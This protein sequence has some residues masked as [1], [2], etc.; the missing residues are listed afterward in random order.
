M[1]KLPTCEDFLNELMEFNNVYPFPE[2]KI[3]DYIENYLRFL[4]NGFM[5]LDLNRILFLMGY[6]DYRETFDYQRGVMLSQH[7]NVS[8]GDIKKVY[9]IGIGCLAVEPILLG[10]GLEESGFHL[11]IEAFDEN[12][13]SSF[14]EQNNK[15]NHQVIKQAIR[16]LDV[17]VNKENFELNYKKEYDDGVRGDTDLFY[18]S[19]LC[20]NDADYDFLSY[21][22]S[23]G[24]AFEQHLCYCN[25]PKF[26]DESVDYIFYENK[27]MNY[28]DFAND[29]FLDNYNYKKQ[30]V[31][32]LD[33]ENTDN[34]EIKPDK[35]ATIRG[36]SRF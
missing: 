33:P 31:E 11:Q 19:R 21:C 1:K 12:G 4:D 10:L 5:S 17:I 29:F 20:E 3:V 18:A 32:L 7:K 2:N 8:N 25:A 23:R 35:S 16:D 14:E 36:Y 9:D 26:E 34:L 24:V 27:L 13:I 6:L 30:E 15:L 28:I 22:I